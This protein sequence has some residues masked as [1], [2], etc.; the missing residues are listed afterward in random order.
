MSKTAPSILV[1][2]DEALIA[3]H[4]ASCL[5]EMQYTVAGICDN[6]QDAIAFLKQQT[7]SLVLIDIHLKGG[8]DGVDLAHYINTNIRLPFI[9]LTGNSDHQTIERVKFTNPQA[10]VLKPYTSMDLRTTIQLVLHKWEAQPQV[11]NQEDS[12]F[13]KDKHRLVR[14][15]YKDI[16]FAE[17]MDNY[18]I[19]YTATA[20]YI[21]PHTLKLVEEKL[22]HHKF[23]RSHRSYLVNLDRIDAVN[24]KTIEVMGKEIPVSETARAVLVAKFNLL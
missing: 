4:I 1:I 13:V 22:Q 10:F 20:K 17:A 3:D 9:F 7:V 6:A 19:I 12:F 2:E 5:E 21:L 14:V 16:G 23:F 8:M 15:Y 18:C 24:P 11:N